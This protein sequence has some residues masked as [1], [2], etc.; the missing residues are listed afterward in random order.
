MLYV[1]HT[2]EHSHP[3]QSE[4]SE[5]EGSHGRPSSDTDLYNVRV[6]ACLHSPDFCPLTGEVNFGSKSLIKYYMTIPVG[7]G[8]TT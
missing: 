8:R 4:G 1:M 5:A 3:V 6:R 2:H 7:H